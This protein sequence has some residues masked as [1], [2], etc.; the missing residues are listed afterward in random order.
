MNVLRSSQKETSKKIFIGLS[1]ILITLTVA[2]TVIQTQQTQNL[3]SSADSALKQ[4]DISN[5]KI[6]NSQAEKKVLSLVNTLRKEKGLQPVAFQ[7]NLNRSAA[8]MSDDQAAQKKMN[9][10][11]SKN[12]GPLQRVKDCGY[13]YAEIRENVGEDTNDPDEIFKAWKKSN[14]HLANMLCASCTEIG[15]AE[16]KKYWTLNIGKPLSVA[17]DEPTSIPNQQADPTSEPT[18]AT[19]PP[20]NT[21]PD[22]VDETI[23][24]ALMTLPEGT[25]GIKASVMIRGI[26]ENGNTT[27][28]HPNRRVEITI[29]DTLD[30]QLASVEGIVSY[31]QATRLFS[32]A[33][34]LPESLP[35]GSYLI[36]IRMPYS[37]TETISSGFL[38]INKSSV[39]TIPVVALPVIDFNESN[40]ITITDFFMIRDCLRDE[41]TEE[42]F[43]VNDDGEVTILDFNITSEVFS[44]ESG[45]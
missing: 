29:S 3:Q 23:P 39:T 12:R 18:V 36:R 4:C 2:L 5:A 31:D 11:D 41:C 6:E 27:P 33:I 35:T 43:D 16:D 8:W 1:F 37:L 20:K 45:E 40:T 25:T 21:E 13:F 7:N 10:K 38:Q 30:K 22:S 24:A 19:N 14:D 28:R 42:K 17:D 26:G 32:G 15:I 9:H 34:A 44:I